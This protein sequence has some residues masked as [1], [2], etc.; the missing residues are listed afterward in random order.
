MH[1]SKLLAILGISCALESNIL[2]FPKF[3]KLLKTSCK[4]RIRVNGSYTTLY[5]ASTL[6]NF[7][8]KIAR[9]QSSTQNR[10]HRHQSTK[11]DAA[12]LLTDRDNAHAQRYTIQCTAAHI[13]HKYTVS[14]I[15]NITNDTQTVQLP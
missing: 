4:V 15:K 10:L 11:S 13:Y 7:R 6:R 8:N 9:W 2:S 5:I 12:T 3:Y 1:L 14:D